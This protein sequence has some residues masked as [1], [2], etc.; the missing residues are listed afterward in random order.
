MV[1]ETAEDSILC[2]FNIDNCTFNKNRSHFS[3]AL[4]LGFEHD[5]SNAIHLLCPQVE[6]MIRAKFKEAN[7][8]TSNVDRQ[9]IEN[10][11]GLSFDI[12]K[13]EKSDETVVCFFLIPIGDYE[14][15]YGVLSSMKNF[16]D[17]V[18][19]LRRDKSP[20]LST[21]DVP[22]ENDIMNSFFKNALF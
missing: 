14:K 15:D 5:F 6:H 20:P 12:M 3:S 9:G 16:H 4:W 17:K 18:E 1:V 19:I 13:E 11:N 22:W 8:L 10:E 7:I 21:H 2:N